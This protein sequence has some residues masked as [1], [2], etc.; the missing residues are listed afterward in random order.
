M[1]IPIL[2]TQWILQF[3]IKAYAIQISWANVFVATANDEVDNTAD[4]FRIP[5]MAFKSN[6]LTPMFYNY[7]SGTAKKIFTHTEELNLNEWYA[8]E[9]KQESDGM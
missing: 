2:A 6:T 1:T 5:S 7:V 4:G 8:I 9:M 3:D